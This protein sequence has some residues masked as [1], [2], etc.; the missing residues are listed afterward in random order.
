M[1]LL[2]II[3]RQSWRPIDACIFCDLTFAMLIN[4]K[5]V[6]PL[7]W[8]GGIF[9]WKFLQRMGFGS[10]WKDWVSIL[11]STSTTTTSLNGSRSAWFSDGRGLAPSTKEIR[12]HRCSSSLHLNL[13]KKNLG[14]AVE[15]GTLYDICCAAER[16][17][18]ETKLVCGWCSDFYQPLTWRHSHHKATPRYLLQRSWGS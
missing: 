8:W 11:L 18:I 4:L 7:T 9:L 13:Y 17:K 2:S 1:L 14:L 15:H 3:I 10:R 6:V 12:C 16:S 5:N